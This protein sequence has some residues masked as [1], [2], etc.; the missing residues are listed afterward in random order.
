MFGL[1]NEIIG[2]INNI[3]NKYSKTFVLFGSRA[4]GDYKKNSDIDIA[5]IEETEQNENAII[6]QSADNSYSL[7]VSI[8]FCPT[9]CSYCSFVFHT[10]SSHS[11]HILC[12]FLV[13]NPQ[14]AHSF[15]KLSTASSKQV[16]SCPA[17]GL[18]S[19]NG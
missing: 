13:P 7:Y 2:K 17:T 1:S 19:S 12:L 11:P 18:A 6:C 3:T 8:P 16:K 4:R 14:N 5:I 9:R 10:Q 15:S